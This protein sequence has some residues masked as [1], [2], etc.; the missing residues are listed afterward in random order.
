MYYGTT[1]FTEATKFLG[2]PLCY[3]HVL[4]TVRTMPNAKQIPIKS[5]FKWVVPDS[6][7]WNWLNNHIEYK[8]LL[9]KKGITSMQ[10]L[11][12][13]VEQFYGDLRAKEQIADNAWKRQGLVEY[14]L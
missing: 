13:Q 11:Y 1:Q 6:D 9:I 5:G 8:K 12:E 7:I 10:E 2:R 14:S 3:A 4:R